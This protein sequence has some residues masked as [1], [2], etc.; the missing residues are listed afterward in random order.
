MK[1][2]IVKTSENILVDKTKVF[3]RPDEKQTISKNSWIVKIPGFINDVNGN[4]VD[5]VWELSPKLLT[6]EVFLLATV[7][8]V[9]GWIVYLDTTRMGNSSIDLKETSTLLVGSIYDTT[10]LYRIRSDLSSNF[11]IL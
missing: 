11:R 8:S 4:S 7:K 6:N 2:L 5:A 3:L 1:T 9:D 10:S